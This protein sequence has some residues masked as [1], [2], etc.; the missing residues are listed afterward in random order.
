MKKLTTVKITS[1]TKYLE[2]II[3][4]ITGMAK[5]EFFR[6]AIDSFIENEEIVEDEL[7]ITKKTD[8]DYIVKDER[9]LIYL[10]DVRRD[11][12]EEIALQQNTGITIVIFQALLNYCTKMSSIVPEDILKEIIGE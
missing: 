11:K 9:E 1:K 8:P 12:L 2:E 4:K 7:K 5:A 6:R 10:D 3:C